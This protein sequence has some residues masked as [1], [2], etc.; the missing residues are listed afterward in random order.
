MPPYTAEENR[1]CTF[2]RR[3]GVGVGGMEWVAGRRQ[4]GGQE[5]G[6]TVCTLVPIEQPD[7]FSCLS[8]S[9][10]VWG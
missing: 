8:G 6:G 4:V 10:G 7:D 5:E 2:Y 3:D 1:D 9:Y